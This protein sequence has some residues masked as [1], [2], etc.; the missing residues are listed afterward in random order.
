MNYEYECKS[1]SAAS[2]SSK[3]VVSYSFTI[4]F[5][6]FLGIHR[7]YTGYIGIGIAQLLTFGGC[8]LWA[9]IDL[10][11]ILANKFNDAKGQTLEGYNKAVAIGLV[12]TLLLLIVLSR[13]S[14][15]LSIATSFAGQS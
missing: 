8:G 7:F 14:S 5:V 11:C 2:N 3:I 4:I 12:V 15:I 10:I 6:G 9:L 1:T 13:F